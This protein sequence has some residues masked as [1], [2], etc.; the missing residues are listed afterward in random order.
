ML[1]REHYQFSPM[2]LVGAGFLAWSALPLESRSR[3]EWTPVT[4]LLWFLSLSI[5]ALACLTGSHWVGLISFLVMLAALLKM[6]LTDSG[7]AK[8]S[9]A[10]AFL[11]LAV[12]LPLNLDLQL[13]TGLQKL[14]SWLASGA[15]D[16][17]SIE[18]AVSGIAIRTVSKAYM[19]EEACSGIHSLFSAVTAMAF[20]GVFFRYGYPRLL[21]TIA[22][23]LVCV[24]AANALR[25]FLIVYADA[26]HG[27]SLESGLRH[28]LL[29]VTTYA[30]ALLLALMNDQFLRFLFPM[31][32]GERLSLLEEMSQETFRPLL[33]F[34]K[35]VLNRVLL[36]GRSA[37]GLL[38]ATV[39]L[40][41]VPSAGYGSLK[42]LMPR[43]GA[44]T[45]DATSMNPLDVRSLSL[46]VLP[47]E[48][49]VFRRKSFENIQRDPSDAF[50]LTSQVWTFEGN[51]QTVQLSLD[52]PYAEFHDLAYCYTSSGWKLQSGTNSST[53]SGKLEIPH[54]EL[55]LYQNQGTNGLVMFTC[56][57]SA[58]TAVQPP[59]ASGNFLRFLRNRL[60]STGLTGNEP[61][62]V[63]PPV[64]QVQLMVNSPEELLPHEVESLRRLFTDARSL[65]LSNLT[66]NK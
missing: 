52:G 36:K 56:F 16:L 43:S 13:I 66:P 32:N 61:P 17:V 12:P 23:T 19:V 58:G 41:I 55:R 8:V 26:R 59:I 30:T 34:R 5:Y 48:L 11:W 39:I 25:V 33:D 35:N 20:F 3:L 18:H 44:T 46:E 4:G 14:A 65:I 27:I 57:D 15:L 24:I 47:E 63:A 37:W 62:P 22:Q 42:H 60:S 53:W 49:G 51:G 9:G 6:T 21:L 2:I 64:V 10:Y 40:V 54:T 29:G 45:M 38:I 28:D 50:G 7:F 31:A 1:G